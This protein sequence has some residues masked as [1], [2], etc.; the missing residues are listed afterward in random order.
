M[1]KIYEYTD[2]RQYLKDYYEDK[3]ANTRRFSFRKFAKE[4][5]I[6]A[7]AT[8]LYVM[9][10]KR[11][12][13]PGSAAQY[14][15]ALGLKKRE[16]EHFVNLV[17]YNQARTAKKKAHYLSKLMKKSR[18]RNVFTVDKDRYE[19]YSQWYHSVIRELVNIFP[20]KDDTKELCRMVRPPISP[21]K[22]RDSLKLLEN[23][24]YIRKKE[25][26][27]FAQTQALIQTGPVQE[28]AVLQFQ[29][30]MLKRGL[31]SFERISKKDKMSAST[32]FSISNKTFE[33][34]K[35]KA[36]DFRKE[37]LQ[38]ASEDQ[39]PERVYQLAMTLFP[40]SKEKKGGTPS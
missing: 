26:G 20:V 12:L 37:L 38:L 22:A 40:V 39:N 28:Y 17:F 16:A 10:G 31:E 27:T 30:E 32:T 5:G 36:R 1:K 35:Q 2:Y 9:E 21:A 19:F 18:I 34:F 13:T 24:G 23:L 3:K 25:D 7:P 4:A 8:L 11:G 6:N 33:V 14:A 29:V 15:N